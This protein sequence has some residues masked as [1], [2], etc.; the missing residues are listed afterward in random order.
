MFRR[1][2]G[3]GAALDKP[4]IDRGAGLVVGQIF[5]P[6]LKKFG[7]AIAGLPVRGGRFDFHQ[8]IGGS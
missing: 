1:H 2:I 8:F 6:D 7:Q 3:S 5:Q 4:H